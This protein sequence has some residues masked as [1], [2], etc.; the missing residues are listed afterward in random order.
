MVLQYSR[1]YVRQDLLTHKTFYIISNLP[2]TIKTHIINNNSLFSFHDKKH[3]I[4]VINITNN[5][6]IFIIYSFYFCYKI[7]Y[8][9]LLNL[10]KLIIIKPHE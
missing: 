7:S 10:N 6:V 9:E 2:L 4:Y 8:S 1:V 5:I 3:H